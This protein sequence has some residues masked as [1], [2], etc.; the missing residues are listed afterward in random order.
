MD[1]GVQRKRSQLGGYPHQLFAAGWSRK[2]K[3]NKTY[4]HAGKKKTMHGKGN[5]I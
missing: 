4:L 1:K 5:E 3:Q 2:T